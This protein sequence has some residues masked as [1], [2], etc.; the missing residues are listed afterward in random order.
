MDVK[1]VGPKDCSRLSVGDLVLEVEDGE[2]DVPERHIAAVRQHGFRIKGE[3][4]PPAPPPVALTQ[5]QMLQRIAE[6]AG[7]PKQASFDQI[8]SRVQALATHAV[9]TQ[10]PQ[11]KKAA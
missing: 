11:G 6:A 8:V 5:W 2:V 10:A 1:M 4:P 9:K 3:A 7:L